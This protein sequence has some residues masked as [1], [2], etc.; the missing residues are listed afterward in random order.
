VECILIGAVG[1]SGLACF[2]IGFQ[3]EHAPRGCIVMYVEI[4]IMYV[5]QWIAFG[6]GITLTELIGVLIM[7]CGIVGSAVEKIMIIR[8]VSS[9][10]LI[11][12][13]SVSSISV[14]V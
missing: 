7:I 5:A 3:L 12:T 10:N 11:I 6:E 14:A 8:K 1:F 13:S 9:E 2:T 4:P